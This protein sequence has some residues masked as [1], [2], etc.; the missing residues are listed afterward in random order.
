MVD[1]DPAD[2]SGHRST[3]E[4]AGLDDP[5]G[6]S[7]ARTLRLRRRGYGATTLA[8]A[9]LMA[10]TV[11]DGA[12]VV[13]AYGVDTARLQASGGGADLEVRYTT[14]TRPALA[15]PFEITVR[16]P[17][18]FDGPVTVA[19][20]HEYMDL[21]DVN[22][23]YPT[24]SSETTMGRWLIWEFDAPEGDTLHFTYDARLEPGVQRGRP[25]AV[26]LVVDG[27]LVGRIDFETSVRA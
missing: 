12:G 23:F 9:A 17:G 14:V 25:G 2:Q 1:R 7:A 20:D 5:G 19:V 13:D 27:A 24:P 18:G 6:A 8:L 3:S 26:A 16:R 10:L 4:A 15:S 21:W 22:G 11:L